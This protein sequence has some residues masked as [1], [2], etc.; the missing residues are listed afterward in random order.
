[1]TNDTRHGAE[2]EKHEESVFEDRKYLELIYSEKRK[3]KTD[4]PARLAAHLR[5]DWY[6][7][8]GTLLDIGCGRGDMLKALFDAKFTVAGVDLSPV[9]AETC[10]PHPVRIADLEKDE[11]PYA[12]A[13]FEYVFSKSVIEHL[14]NPMPFL[15]EAN[16]VLAPGGTA[17]IMTP[18]WMHNNWG[19]F[20]I[21]STH[22]TPFTAPSLRDAMEMAGFSQVR[23]I[24]FYQLPFLW[25]KPWLVP[26]IRL[27]AALPL[28][29]RPMYE[30]NLP[31]KLNTL[32]RF[33]KEVM[34]LA[35]GNKS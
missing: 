26:I 5:D 27:L 31:P 21:D 17:V 15:K 18:S 2:Q 34:L 6:G 24:H 10:K 3:P 8:T 9:S 20:Y 29:Y 19:P 32:F 14:R 28:R 16:R 22:V 23:V 30:I 35:I 33:S 4:Y 11:L 1:M 7:G 13:S 25:K 12:T